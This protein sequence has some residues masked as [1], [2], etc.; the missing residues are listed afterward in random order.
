MLG[1]F[2]R[3]LGTVHGLEGAAGLLDLLRR[4]AQILDPDADMMEPDEIAAP[5]VAGLGRLGL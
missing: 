5:L 4:L 2:D 1:M 3:N